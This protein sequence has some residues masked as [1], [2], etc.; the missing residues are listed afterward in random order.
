MVVVVVTIVS[1]HLAFL[2]GWFYPQVISSNLL[3]LLDLMSWEKK[4]TVTPLHPWAASWT[5]NFTFPPTIKIS[6]FR[7]LVTSNQHARSRIYISLPNRLS[8]PWLLSFS[9]RYLNSPRFLYHF[10]T[11]IFNLPAGFLKSFS[12][13]DSWT[14]LNCFHF[15]PS[16]SFS[17]PLCWVSCLLHPRII[18]VP[19]D[20]ILRSIPGDEDC[21]IPFFILTLT[22]QSDIKFC[23]V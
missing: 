17:G 6:S 22:I 21:L 8:S 18:G 13:S 19:G 5:L 15:Y 16:A 23:W 9:K 2:Y 4:I 11:L 14:P 12:L 3:F 10:S 7:G 1:S 20:S